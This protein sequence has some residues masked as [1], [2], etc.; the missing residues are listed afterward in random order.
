MNALVIVESDIVKGGYSDMEIYL[1]FCFKAPLI[2]NNSYAQ[3]L[4]RTTSS[5]LRLPII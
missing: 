2:Q 5:I 4:L 1:I 3:N